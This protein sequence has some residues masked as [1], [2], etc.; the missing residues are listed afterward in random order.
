MRDTPAF[1]EGF[2]PFRR[3]VGLAVEAIKVVHPG[4]DWKTVVATPINCSP[5]GPWMNIHKNAR[6]TPQGRL[7]MVRRIEEE[8]WKVADAALAAG[9]SKRRVGW[10]LF[11]LLMRAPGRTV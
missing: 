9:I 7:L 10:N 6:L 3:G 5:E 8:G 2:H 1:T 4:Q 11:P